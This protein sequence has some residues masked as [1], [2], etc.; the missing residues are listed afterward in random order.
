MSIIHSPVKSKL[1]TKSENANIMSLYKLVESRI[2][3]DSYIPPEQP[4]FQSKWSKEFQSL[5]ENKPRYG[6]E[7]L[8]RFFAIG[9][10][11][12]L[13]DPLSLFTLKGEQNTDAEDESFTF[14]AHRSYG[15]TS[16][17]VLEVTNAWTIVMETQPVEFFYKTLYPYLIRSLFCV[18]NIV[19]TAPK[20]IVF[21]ENVEFGISTVL[22]SLR[23][24]KSDIIAMFDVNYDAVT[25][26]LK[27]ECSIPESNLL[28]IKMPYPFKDPE[29]ITSSVRNFLSEKRDLGV[30]VRLFVVEHITSPTAVVLPVKEIVE[31]C[32]E[33]GVEILVDGAHAIGQVPLNLDEIGADYY[34]TNCHK[35]LCSSKGCAILYIKPNHQSKIKPLITTWGAPHGFQSS[36]IWQGTQTQSSF[37]S[38]PTC[39]EFYNAIGFHETISR[40]K[41]FAFEAGKF[42]A[43]AWKTQIIVEDSALMAAMC[44]VHVPKIYAG[45]DTTLGVC[46]KDECGLSDLQ[47]DLL[48][49]W[50]IEV[51]IFN[52]KSKKWCR[53]SLHMY[54]DWDDVKKLAKAM[55]MVS[56]YP[57]GHELVVN[58]ETALN[59]DSA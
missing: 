55:L 47:K 6:K 12:L 17:P 19:G 38:L 51:P 1:P 58:L 33:F 26:A 20:N 52:F 24:Q 50:R 10:R 11:K 57:K 22:K 34:T 42:L 15:A 23:F 8:R 27:Y 54:N 5:S 44:V 30:S 2:S 48:E 46:E 25:Y 18:A 53:V 21:V 14:L 49:K 36:F 13:V 7:I 59:K 41:F 43:S 28:K 3:S 40:N 9:N 31:V 45:G 4:A 35:W 16:L 56:G 32:H 37:L 39:I 29:T